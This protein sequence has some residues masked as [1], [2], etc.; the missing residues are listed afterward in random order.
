MVIKMWIRTTVRLSMAMDFEMNMH[1]DL[2]IIAESKCTLCLHPKH[3]HH[4]H[5]QILP[6]GGPRAQI[7]EI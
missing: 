5:H 4:Q 1:M 3:R 6:D 7:E 2:D